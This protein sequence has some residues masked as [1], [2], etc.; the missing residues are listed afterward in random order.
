MKLETNGPRPCQ[1]TQ[2]NPDK[3]GL[4]A[5]RDSVFRINRDPTK[6]LGAARAVSTEAFDAT[7]N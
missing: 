5:S 6:L 1:S 2:H 3:S 4:D 7:F